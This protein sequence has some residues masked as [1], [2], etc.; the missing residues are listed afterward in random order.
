MESPVGRNAGVHAHHAN[1]IRSSSSAAQAAAGSV[2]AKCRCTAA[3]AMPRYSSSA[4]VTC[5]VMSRPM[6]CTRIS[7]APAHAEAELWMRERACGGWTDSVRTWRW[8]PSRADRVAMWPAAYS[9]T[10]IVAEGRAQVGAKKA[11]M[12]WRNEFC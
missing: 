4:S 3:G 1:P 11:S 8:T 6:T 2:A 7:T 10:V 9:G 5:V 12:E